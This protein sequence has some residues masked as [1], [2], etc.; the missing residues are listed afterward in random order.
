MV[1]T[2]PDDRLEYKGDCG[3][4]TGPDGSKFKADYTEHLARSFETQTWV[5]EQASGMSQVLLVT[6]HEARNEYAN[7]D[8]WLIPGWIM[9]TWKT[10]QAAD[11]S[12]AT[13]ITYG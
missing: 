7:Q 12:M 3:V 6:G 5:Y 9:W 2:C 4:K 8:T 11:W 10:E 13:G 1:K